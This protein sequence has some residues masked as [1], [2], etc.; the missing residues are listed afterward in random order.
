MYTSNIQNLCYQEDA[1]GRSL[2]RTPTGEPY[3]GLVV[4]TLPSGCVTAEYEVKNG[5]KDG[6]EKEFYAP[7]EPAQ[8]AHYRRGLLHGDVTLYHP[9]G[10]PKEKSVF[11]HGIC[12]EEFQW[13]EAGQLMH[14]QVLKLASYQ[15]VMLKNNRKEFGD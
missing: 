12:L 14:H 15:Q 7:D 13:D 2:L 11:A 8:E 10:G 1:Q 5:L 6:L 9:E 4:E 3:T